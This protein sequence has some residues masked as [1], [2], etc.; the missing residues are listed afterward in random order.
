MLDPTLPDLPNSCLSRSEGS[1]GYEAP[2]P[3]LLLELA[4]SF[5]LPTT[6]GSTS[7]SVRVFL[8]LAVMTLA[9][10]LGAESASNL[11]ALS[12]IPFRMSLEEVSGRVA[13]N[14]DFLHTEV[15]AC[16]EFR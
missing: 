4:G 3:L 14:C 11:R 7:E 1:G 2:A 10:S 6:P 13:F 8:K 9:L 15:S 5:G 12:A 16:V